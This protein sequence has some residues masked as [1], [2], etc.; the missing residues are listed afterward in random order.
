M[1][2]LPIREFERKQKSIPTLEPIATATWRVRPSTFASM[3][4][5]QVGNQRPR[6]EGRNPPVLAAYINH[7]VERGAPRTSR[8]SKRLG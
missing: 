7:L 4:R 2:A 3:S 6:H 8:R 1:K 5:H